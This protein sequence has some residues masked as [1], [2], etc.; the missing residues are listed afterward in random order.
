MIL[1]IYL[2]VIGAILVVT[3]IL[4]KVLETSGG[5]AWGAQHKEWHSSLSDKRF[6]G[7]VDGG[8]QQFLSLFDLIYGPKFFS[9]RRIIASFIST[10]LFLIFVLLILGFEDTLF[11]QYIYDIR[12]GSSIF[13]DSL[14]IFILFYLFN[15][16]P[17]FLSLQET[18]WTLKKSQG[19]GAMG[20]SLWFLVDI[21]LTYLIFAVMTVILYAIYD[22]IVDDGGLI[23]ILKMFIPFSYESRILTDR[24]AFL[25][26]LITTYFTSFIWFLFVLYTFMLKAAVSSSLVTKN[27]VSR[28]ASDLPAANGLGG[29]MLILTTI[30]FAL[31]WAVSKIF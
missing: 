11:T 6:Q 21:I 3:S 9:W 10:T 20:I 26:L 1:Q 23:D 24:T 22:F 5:K 7:A 30:V 2:L 15:L 17:D 14:G 31:I 8:N 28:L 18:R 4:N 25:P 13:T 27:I 19:R 16:V 29:V 12:T